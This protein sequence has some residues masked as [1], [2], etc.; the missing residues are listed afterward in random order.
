[1]AVMGALAG[2]A[3]TVP[4]RWWIVAV[5]LLDPFTAQ[6]FERNC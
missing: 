2:M 5:E 3:G 1:M 4:S 6:A